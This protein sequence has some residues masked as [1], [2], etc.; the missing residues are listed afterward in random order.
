MN[1]RTH[2]VATPDTLVGKPRIKDTRISVALLVRCVASEWSFDD[3]FDSYP[4][5][6]REDILAAFAFAADLL[7]A[8]QGIGAAMVNSPQVS[9]DDGCE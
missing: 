4:R 7:D 3:I 2:I 9:I 6:K 8:H 1:W 5:I